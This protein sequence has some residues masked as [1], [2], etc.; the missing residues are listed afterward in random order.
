MSPRR[1][2]HLQPV[3]AFGNWRALLSGKMI[4]QNIE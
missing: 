1:D 3:K 2:N 4:L